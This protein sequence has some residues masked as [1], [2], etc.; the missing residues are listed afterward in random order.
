MN[1]LLQHQITANLTLASAIAERMSGSNATPAAIRATLAVLDDVVR[2]LIR[3]DDS[4]NSPGE[5]A[6]DGD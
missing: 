5:A 3:L 1:G 4:L 2:D 6:D